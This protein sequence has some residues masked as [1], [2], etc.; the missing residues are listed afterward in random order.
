MHLEAAETAYLCGDLQQL[1]VLAERT[2]THTRSALDQA[3]VYEI[4]LRALVAFNEL[5][6]ALELGHEVLDLLGVP[7]S[8]RMNSFYAITLLTRLLLRTVRMRTEHVADAWPMTDPR[9][10]AAMRILMIMC[11]AGYLS[12][13][14]ATAL[15]ILRMTQLSLRH[16]L[17]PESS[18][19]YPMFGALLI[20]NLGTIE[21]GY[22]FGMLA[23]DNLS[24]DNREL[25]CKTIFLVNNFIRIWKHH[26]RE[27]L[28][29][30]GN[31]YRIGMETGDVE[32]ALISAI[33]GSANAFTIG[34]D[35]HSLE[36]NLAG[37]NQKASELNQTP[38]LSMGSI[39]QQAARNLMNPNAAPWLLE[40]EIYSENELLQFHQDSGDESSIAHL[41]IVKLFLAVLFNHREHAPAFARDARSRL[42]SVV[43]SPA[44]PFFTLYE[45]LACIFAIEARPG[46]LKTAQHRLRIRRNQRRLRKWAR[47]APENVLHGY[48]LVEAELARLRGD[49]TAALD[50]YDEAISR[51]DTHGYLKEFG[52]A[53]ERCGRFHLKANKRDLALFYLRQARASYVRWGALTKVSALDTEFVELAD[54]E[55]LERRR[56]RGGTGSTELASPAFRS[57]GNYLDLGSVI[58][59]SQVLSGEIIL[60]NLLERLMQVALEN[61]GAHSASLVLSHN[62][63]LVL[64]ITTRYEGISSRH[65]RKSI[66]IEDA[67]DLPV[68]IIQYVARTQEDLVLNDALNE[69][70]F[71][72]DEYLMTHQPKSILCIP[73]LS[74]SHL[75]GVMY[76]ENLQTTLAFTQE[77][78]AILKLLASQSAI[79]IENAKALPTTRRIERQVS[80]SVPKRRRRYFRD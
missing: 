80:V 68:S 29:P 17:A 31:A 33:T 4:K 19:A 52:L 45:S 51:A 6:R 9:Y 55:N 78:V 73:I 8:D 21:L 20:S 15:Y 74:K 44:V 41:F 70:I 11:Q 69:D 35:L 7:A 66:P 18:F 56:Q 26:I 79:A 43:S 72:Q 38:I 39:Y 13:S 30:L 76:L 60:D 24:D 37:H 14:E 12:G 54:A 25:H 49:T 32:F 71:T 67:K 22:R 1:E 34:H 50:H 28:E 3:R 64:E 58:K 36:S 23:H 57:Y 42:A 47:H 59:A 2:L 27:S 5:D 16:G 10:L 53:N 62:D 40:G 65:E 48:H 63:E 75:T 77:R 46:P 61:A